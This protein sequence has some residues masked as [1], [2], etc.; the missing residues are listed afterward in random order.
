MAPY[1]AIL[2]HFRH[3]APFPVFAKWKMAVRHFYRHQR[4]L[5]APYGAIWRHLAPFIGA[6]WRHLAPSGA[7]WRKWR[8]VRHMARKWRHFRAIWRHMARKWRH[9][10]HVPIWHYCP[11][12]DTILLKWFIADYVHTYH[13]LLHLSLGR[14]KFIGEWKVNKSK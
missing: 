1:G 13:Q 14:Y 11:I 2:R 6:I 10:A 9:M 12:F 5:M 7:I 4:H 3:M 8:H